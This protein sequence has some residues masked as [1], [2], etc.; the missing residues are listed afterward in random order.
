M[1]NLF[2][3]FPIANAFQLWV[4]CCV[5]P[6]AKK[7]LTSWMPQINS[8]S[9][10]GQCNGIP[11]G[12]NVSISR[13]L[14]TVFEYQVFLR[15]R[16]F[17]FVSRDARLLLVTWL[18]CLCVRSHPVFHCFLISIAIDTIHW[19]VSISLWPIDYNFA[20]QEYHLN[21]YWVI[22]L[23]T[24]VDLHSTDK[25]AQDTFSIERFAL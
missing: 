4:T 21:F 20:S 14:N 25:R 9:T 2:V 24:S 23:H 5:L 22:A 15:M 16:Q 17:N 8:I 6:H 19:L 13:F 1:V 11:T 3:S 12:S 7:W 10:Y 18:N